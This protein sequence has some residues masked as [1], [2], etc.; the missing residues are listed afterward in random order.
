MAEEM[1]KGVYTLIYTLDTT[2]MDAVHVFSEMKSFIV[3]LKKPLS[4][5]TGCPVEDMDVVMSMEKY[6]EIFDKTRESAASSPP[7]I[8]HGHYKAVRESKALVRVNLLFMT[9]SSKVASILSRWTKRLHCIIH[10]VQQ[11][12]ATKL[13][14]VQLYKVYFNTMLKHLL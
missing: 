1:R 2:G 7:G 4:N 9:I 8:Y 3:V 6:V 14:I 12:Y 11:L 13:G 5:I 10:N